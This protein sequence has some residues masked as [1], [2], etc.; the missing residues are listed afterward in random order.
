MK[1]VHVTASLK[2]GGAETLLAQVAKR[3]VEAGNEVCIFTLLDHP[4]VKVTDRVKVL[5]GAGPEPGLRK[6]YVAGWRLIRALRDFKPD[7]VHAHMLH[8]NLVTRLLR[9]FLGFPVLV[10]TVHAIRETD[11]ILY[12]RA[13]RLLDRLADVTVFVSREAMERYRVDKMVSVARSQ[14][15]H[16]GIDLEVFRP[17][18]A[19]RARMRKI[20]NINDDDILVTAI[21]RLTPDKDYPNLFA[22]FDKVLSLEPRAYLVI[23]GDGELRDSLRE[24]ASKRSAAPRITFLGMRRDVP[25]I[26]AASDLLVLSSAHEGFGLVLAEA[27]AC[28]V[29]VVSTDCGGTSEVIGDAGTLV[30]PSDPD[31]LAVGILDTLA[32]H[33]EIRSHRLQ[34]AR[35]RVESHFS[36]EST[37][38]NWYEVY[39][40]HAH[41]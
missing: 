29:P 8:S 14:V 17:D 12:K 31:A 34:R 24:Q 15:I 28:G 3:Q 35:F 22:A 27:M 33:P 11:D 9:P 21:G 41:G 40:R 4:D 16:N 39:R 36:L 26:L 32:L 25:D 6:Y 38:A 30:P 10:N 13:Y 19:S 5:P 37:V 18:K 1:I 7:V 23:V 20:L 2:M